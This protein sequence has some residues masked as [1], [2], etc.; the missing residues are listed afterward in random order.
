MRIGWGGVEVR[1]AGLRMHEMG[2]QCTVLA[3][4]K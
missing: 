3:S 4:L 1:G 2:K